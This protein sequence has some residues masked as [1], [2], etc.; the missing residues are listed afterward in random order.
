MKILVNNIFYAVIS[1][2][3]YFATRVEKA[4]KGFGTDDALLIRVLVSRDEID[5]NE[6][7][8]FYKQLYKKDMIE[9]IKSDCSGDYETLLV[10]LV[11]H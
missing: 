10:C 11:S 8:Q 7:K 1:P 2:S 9:A 6:I 4:I 5:M 3:E